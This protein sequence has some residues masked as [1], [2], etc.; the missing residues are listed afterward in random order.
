MAEKIKNSGLNIKNHVSNVK[1][2]VTFLYHNNIGV[3]LKHKGMLGKAL[4]EYAKALKLNPDFANGY[5]NR[6][7]LYYEI[8]RYEK[9]REEW[10]KVLKID[11]NNRFVKERFGQAVSPDNKV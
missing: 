7:V 5:Y 3:F 11:P 9:A 6:G 8:G 2:K 1:K 4:E 10:E